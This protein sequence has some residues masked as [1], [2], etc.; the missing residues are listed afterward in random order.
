MNFEQVMAQA[1]YDLGWHE[2]SMRRDRPYNGQPHTSTGQRGATEV[3]GVTFRDLRDCYIRAICQA[4]GADHPDNM[5][6]YDEAGKGEAAVLC[7]EDI[8]K[9]KGNPDRMAVFQNFACE[10]EKL[11][12]I[13]PNVPKLI[14][15]PSSDGDVGGS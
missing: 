2:H 13:Y 10:V 3:K 6:Y 7:E 8:Y 12:G 11:M 1:G 4:L 14:F 9:L 15:T 5:P